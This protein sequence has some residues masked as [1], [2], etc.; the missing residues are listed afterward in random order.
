MWMIDASVAPWA[1]FRAG[2]NPGCCT[3][4]QWAEDGDGVNPHEPVTWPAQGVS[5]AGALYVDAPGLCQV[6]RYGTLPPV[7]LDRGGEHRVVAHYASSGG[8]H[9]VLWDDGWIGVFRV[10]GHV[11][12]P[13]VG[14]T[15]AA[16]MR[17]LAGAM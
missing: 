10:S 17:C 15:E 12:A 4:P 9:I 1:A 13:W 7:P 2:A 11:T 3:P 5:P 6:W 14:Q 8:R 16:I